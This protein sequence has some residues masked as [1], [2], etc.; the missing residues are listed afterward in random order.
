[1]STLDTQRYGTTAE[2]STYTGPL[3]EV[4]VDTDKDTAVVHDGTTPGGHPLAKESDVDAIKM[5][6][7]D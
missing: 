2:H 1:M 3:A 5:Y 7:Q 6:Y 4:T